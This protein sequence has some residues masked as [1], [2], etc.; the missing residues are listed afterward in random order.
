MSG[1]GFGALLAGYGTV[2]RLGFG[3]PFGGTRLS[4]RFRASK[5][6]EIHTPCQSPHKG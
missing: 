1:W 2:L 4:L 5:A 3:E 6:Y